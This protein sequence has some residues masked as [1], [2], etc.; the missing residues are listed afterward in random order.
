MEQPTL[1]QGVY[2]QY[3]NR[4]G[5]YLQRIN[6][7]DVLRHAGYV[8]NRKDGLRWPTYVKTDSEGKRVHG[9]KFIVTSNGQCCFQPPERKNYNVISFIKEHPSLFAEYTPDMKPD[10]LVNLVCS[11]ILHE[12]EPVRSAAIVKPSSAAE[13]FDISQYTMQK[14]NEDKESYRPFWAYFAP[15]GIN[16]ATMKA[17]SENFAIA[18]KELA[19]GKTVRNL[20]FPMSIPGKYGCVGMELR[21]LKRQDGT[22]YK[23]MALGS[24]AS[25]GLWM[26]SPY[27]AS[28]WDRIRNVYWFE[29]AY[30]AMAYYQMNRDKFD[31]KRGLFVS[32]GGTPAVGQIRGVLDFTPDA[33]HHL[34]F[35]NDAAGWQY[36]ANFNKLAGTDRTG[37]GKSEDILI[38]PDLIP[39]FLTLPD[40]DSFTSKIRDI[41]TSKGRKDEYKYVLSGNRERLPQ[42]FLDMDEEELRDALVDYYDIYCGCKACAKDLE[43]K[44]A[45]YG[46][47]DVWQIDPKLLPAPL[48]EIFDEYRQ[49]SENER[50]AA[51]GDGADAFEEEKREGNLKN[52]SQERLENIILSW[53]T[54]TVRNTPAYSVIREVPETGFKDWN[55]QLIDVNEKKKEA[56]SSNQKLTVDESEDVEE[57]RGYGR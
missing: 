52:K 25:E 19:D 10:K 42:D 46:Y 56:V 40:R 53:T 27:P 18:T 55:E 36:V 57:R 20:A 51:M 11:N 28:G 6:I 23:G 39:Y 2:S 4:Y 45:E 7:Q 49:H 41:F 5:E 33:T 21:G 29:S 31:V 16:Y 15:R 9:D 54:M 43:K 34:C 22:S 38:R 8:F 13:P 37:S 14:I 44:T 32:T 48:R 24:N 50:F 47:R 30:D 1:Q 12:P 35:D 3:A 17:F 26:A